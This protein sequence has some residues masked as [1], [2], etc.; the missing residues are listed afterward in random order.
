MGK[1]LARH[2]LFE[3]IILLAQP[4]FWMTFRAGGELSY[5]GRATSPSDIHHTPSMFVMSWFDWRYFP[6]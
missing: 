3:G 5:M 6:H 4:T 2:L 1:F